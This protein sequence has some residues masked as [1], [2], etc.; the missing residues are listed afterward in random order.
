MTP[1]QITAIAEEIRKDGRFQ[2]LYPA[3]AQTQLENIITSHLADEEKLE[4]QPTCEIYNM[5][6]P[7]ADCTCKHPTPDKSL[8]YSIV[9]WLEGEV[10][11]TKG[12]STE[13]CHKLYKGTIYCCNLS[14]MTGDGALE[15]VEKLNSVASLR[16]CHA[17]ELQ[18]WGKKFLA[19]QAENK[20]HEMWAEEVADLKRLHSIETAQL[21]EQNK[22]LQRKLD[23]HQASET[24]V[25]CKQKYNPSLIESSHCIFCIAKG[26]KAQIGLITAEQ[27]MLVEQLTQLRADLTAERKVSDDY[28]RA[29]IGYKVFP[30]LAW[31]REFDEAELLHAELRKAT[32]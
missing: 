4:H 27:D 23:E 22:E 6:K 32:V 31:E 15:L 14:G 26:F 28:H 10:R 29:W 3:F 11:R 20:Q 25:I 19:L 18:E 16:R 2:M 9:T 24:C 8:E 13:Y 30:S 17:A 12:A 21:V 1:H 7:H 5:D